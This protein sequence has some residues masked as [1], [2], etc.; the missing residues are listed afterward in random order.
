M[1]AHAV[2]AFGTVLHTS[3]R[4]ANWR[5]ARLSWERL[6]PRIIQEIGYVEPNLNALSFISPQTGWIVGE[7]GLVLHTT[8]GGQTWNS[9]RYGRTLPQLFGV[10]FYD[11]RTG[12]AIGQE[13]NL[14]KTMDGGKNWQEIN[15]GTKKGLYGISLRGNHG[16]IVGDWVMLQTNNGGSDWLAYSRDLWLSG[17]AMREGKAIAVGQAGTLL[18]IELE[19]KKAQGEKGHERMGGMA[20]RP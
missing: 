5:K 3:G 20:L 16:V 12:L 13:G 2:G 6:I 8:N 14:L 18:Q 9:Q 1:E 7:Y 11:E 19:R 10:E 17:V 15:T 4:G